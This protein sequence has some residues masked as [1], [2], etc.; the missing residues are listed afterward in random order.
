MR[1]EIQKVFPDCRVPAEV[2]A[3]LLRATHLRLYLRDMTKANPGLIDEAVFQVERNLVA[4]RFTLGSRRTE[5]SHR[6]FQDELAFAKTL[7]DR[8]SRELITI[9]AAFDLQCALHEMIFWETRRSADDFEA[10]VHDLIFRPDAK[11]AEPPP[12]FTPRPAG[13]EGIDW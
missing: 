13:T 3:Y 6:R 1:N 5:R 8:E 10:F 7:I 2:Q 4:V 11:T 12:P 9:L